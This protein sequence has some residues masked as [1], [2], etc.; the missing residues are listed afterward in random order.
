[1]GVVGA[2]FGVHP[3]KMAGGLSKRSTQGVKGLRYHY[4]NLLISKAQRLKPDQFWD[5]IGVCACH[6]NVAK[7]ASCYPSAPAETSYEKTLD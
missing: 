7:S 6:N 2:K 1:M 5:E 4:H 3:L